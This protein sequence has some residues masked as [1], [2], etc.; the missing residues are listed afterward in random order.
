MMT[1]QELADF[2]REIPDPMRAVGSKIGNLASLP[3]EVDGYLFYTNVHAENDGRVWTVDTIRTEIAKDAGIPEED[4][5]V[6]AFKYEDIA[7][8]IYVRDTHFAKVVDFAAEVVAKFMAETI[9]NRVVSSALERAME[10]I[11]QDRRYESNSPV[12]MIMP[13]G[14]IPEC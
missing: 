1:D 12:P 3:P 7:W 11:E 9:V 2:K 5:L 4:V 10:K 13:R 8:A 6:N 14:G